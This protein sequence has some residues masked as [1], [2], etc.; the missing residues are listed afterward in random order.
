M[1]SK[2]LACKPWHSARFF[3]EAWVQATYCWRLEYTHSPDVGRGH[4]EILNNGLTPSC[5][6][7]RPEY[8]IKTQCTVCKE[9]LSECD[10]G[11]NSAHWQLFGILHKHLKPGMPVIKRIADS[12]LYRELCAWEA[13]YLISTVEVCAE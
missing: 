6:M 1:S 8:R 10:G 11:Y 9:H 5:E 12:P 2:W 7:V 13:T 4:Q 3:S